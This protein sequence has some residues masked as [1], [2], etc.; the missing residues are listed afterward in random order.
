MTDSTPAL[1]FCPPPNPI[2]K[3]A[4]GLFESQNQ[5][6]VE[7]MGRRGETATTKFKKLKSIWKT[8]QV[9]KLNAKLVKTN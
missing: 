7:R 9:R 5:R 3:T 6:K 8:L 1:A 2:K 4:K